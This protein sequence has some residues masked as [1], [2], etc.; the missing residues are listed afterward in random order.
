V[1]RGDD[2]RWWWR[3]LS[4]WGRSLE[5]G[6]DHGAGGAVGR[7]G[8]LA[9]V[10]EVS[11]PTEGCYFTKYLPLNTFPARVSKFSLVIGSLFEDFV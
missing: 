1:R 7:V 6:G 9:I 5:G 8:Q 3:N 10:E 11:V 4:F 2:W